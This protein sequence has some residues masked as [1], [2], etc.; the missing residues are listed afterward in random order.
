MP[1]D[2][3]S[4]PQLSRRLMRMV[5]HDLLFM[6]W[7][8]DAVQLAVHLPD[9]LTLDT[10]NGQA[11]IGIVPF[12]MSGVSL[13]W[14]PDIPWMSRFPELNLRTYV[15]GP[16]GQPGVWFF[17]LDATNPIAVRGA[18]WLY[19]LAYMDAAITSQKKRGCDCGS[20][21]EYTSRRTD[22]KFPEANLKVEYRGIGESRQAQRGTLEHFL[23]HRYSLF[24]ANRKGRLFRGDIEHDPW[25]L[26]DAQAIVHENTICDWLG[27]SLPDTAP[28][29]HFA[30][31]TDVVA[32]PIE[33][34]T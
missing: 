6:H 5:W 31:K 25:E 28:L 17:S 9:G 30:C 33:A 23:T 12:R 13:T 24:S 27:V 8:V 15:T 18:R 7:K 19:N 3:L 21:T 14:L 11:W 26:C 1:V 10:F 4:K 22:S 29:L 16:Q 2:A 32:G 34:V 20:W